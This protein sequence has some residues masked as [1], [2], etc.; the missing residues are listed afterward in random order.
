M[1][2]SILSGLFFGAINL[3]TN[4]FVVLPL[5]AQMVGVILGSGLLFFNSLFAV[6]F[7]KKQNQYQLTWNQ[8]M[9]ASVQAGI[10]QSL[11]YFLSIVLIQRVFSPGFFPELVSFGQYLPILSINIILFSVFSFIFGFI[12]S[13]LLHNQRQ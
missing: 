7:T 11:F 6:L 1:K 4:V 13:S 9:K 8:G 5:K 10:I 3:V 2:P 12:T